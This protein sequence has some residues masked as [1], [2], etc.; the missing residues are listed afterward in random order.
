MQAEEH[1]AGRQGG[2]TEEARGAG[3][4]R[5]A[6]CQAFAIGLVAGGAVLQVEIGAAFVDGGIGGELELD[7]DLL[8]A[9]GIEIFLQ[10]ARG[11]GEFINLFDLEIIEP[12]LAATL[13]KSEQR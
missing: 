6:V 4:R 1:D 9:E 7:G 2:V 12:G 13:A 8:A 3:E 10:V 11:V 5:E